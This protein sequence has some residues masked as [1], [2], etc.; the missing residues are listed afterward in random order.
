VAFVSTPTSLLHRL[1]FAADPV[2]RARFDDWRRGGG[3]DLGGRLFHYTPLALLP[4]SR[5]PLLNRRWLLEA[6]PR[7]TWPGAARHLASNGFAGF[8]L[9]VIDSAL[10]LPLWRRLGSARLV[11]RVTDRNVDFPHQPSGLRA[12]E[13]ALARAAEIV[14]C[15]GDTLLPYV[16][17]LAPKQSLCIPNGVDLAHFREPGAVPADLAAVP[18]PR[19]IYVGSLGAWFDRVL[20]ERLAAALPEVSFV[21]IGPYGDAL[22]GR[23]P[24]PPN[25]HYLGPRPYA[26]IPAYLAGARVGLIPFRRNGMEAF[27]D[28]INPL[29]L[30]EYMAAGLAV[31]TT[32]IA[33]VQALSSPAHVASDEA[34]MAGLVRRLCLAPGDG[35]AERAFAARYDWSR[36]FQ[37]LVERLDL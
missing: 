33:Q 16:A 6:W 24:P 26:S 18:E 1:R 7:L 37:P 12:M 14:V 31:V 9:A 27:V 3:R 19:A 8:D 5:L 34:A 20:V 32:P 21:I 25:L 35:A 4:P 36:L 28:D 2:V 17:R 29:K 22:A 13:Q 11:Y 10:M 30:Y 15:T 23:G